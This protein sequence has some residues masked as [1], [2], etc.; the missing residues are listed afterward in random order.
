MNSKML[1]THLQNLIDMGEKV[2][3]CFIANMELASKENDL[4]AIEFHEKYHLE[5]FDCLY[6]LPRKV[7]VFDTVCVTYTYI[8]MG[9]VITPNK[10]SITPKIHVWLF[11]TF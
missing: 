10:S 5:V 1:K 7:C 11:P 4:W 8:Y 9:M 2:R 6:F 3:V